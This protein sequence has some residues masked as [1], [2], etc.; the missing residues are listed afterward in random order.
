MGFDLRAGDEFTFADNRLPLTPTLSPKGRG[1]FERGE[2]AREGVQ[3]CLRR[4]D[5][6][7]GGHAFAFRSKF[8][9]GGIHD[10]FAHEAEGGELAA[11][12]G[13]HSGHA[14]ARFVIEQGVRAAHLPRLGPARIVQRPHTGPGS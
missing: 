11:D 10:Q 8:L 1:G 9:A 6:S 4:L 14:V 3:F 7:L 12:H 5:G 13:E 2:T